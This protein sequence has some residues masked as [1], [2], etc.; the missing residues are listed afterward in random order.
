[1]PDSEGLGEALEAIAD[2]VGDDMSRREIENL[3]PENGFY[4]AL[5]FERVRRIDNYYEDGG[6]AYY[7][8]LGE[9]GLADRL[10]N[11]FRR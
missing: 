7:L 9:A 1:M 11:L 10:S 3:F 2:R 6:S 4:E 5:G 8:R